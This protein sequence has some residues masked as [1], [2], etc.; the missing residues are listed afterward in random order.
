MMVPLPAIRGIRSLEW[1]LERSVAVPSSPTN[2]SLQRQVRDGDRWVAGLAFEDHDGDDAGVLESFLRQAIRGDSWL[3]LS[4]PQSTV[5]GNWNPADLITNGTLYA[6]VTT[7]WNAS[8]STLSVNARR[9]KVKNT[10]AGSGNANQLVTMEANKPHVLLV[11]GW[12]GVATSAQYLVQR[13]SDSVNEVNSSVTVPAR[14]VLL[15][16]PTVASMRVLL[17]VNEAVANRDLAFSGVSLTRCLQVNGASQTGTR[18]N[19][20]GGPASVNAALKA[21]EYVCLL[22]GSNYQLVQLVED[23]DSDS[24]GAG[25][26]AFE[27]ALRGSPA[28]NAAV[29]VRYPFGRFIVGGHRAPSSIAPPITRDFSIKVEEDVTP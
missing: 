28:D 2:R 7:D 21:G 9:L 11:D 25:T 8:G 4:P 26:L 1:E 18:L 23:F 6:G 17:V 15:V 22:V 5:R 12:R 19:V 16:T 13:V 27:P 24:A 20:D 3:Y 10:G 14:T 29:I